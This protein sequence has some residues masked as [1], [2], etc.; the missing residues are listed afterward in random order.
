MKNKKIYLIFVF[1]FAVLAVNLLL[2]LQVWNPSWNPFRPS[3]TIALAKMAFRMKRVDAFHALGEVELEMENIIVSSEF[4][5]DLE[6]VNDNESKIKGS[7]KI[8][9]FSER[10]EFLTMNDVFYLNPGP[11]T[12]NIEEMTKNRFVFGDYKWIKIDQESLDSL[13][14]SEI[15]KTHPIL[16]MSGEEWEK[17]TEEIMK[18]FTERKY[19][20]I[21]AELEDEEIDGEMYYHYLISLNEEEIQRMADRLDFVSD[22]FADYQ[23]NTLEDE[24]KIGDLKD[25]DFEVWIDQDDYYLYQIKYEEND[26]SRSLVT[27]INFSD[28]NQEQNINP[29]EE[30]VEIG[31]ILEKIEE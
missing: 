15:S 4:D 23:N 2:Y 24:I 28:F 8:P 9:M 26:G 10:V 12:V 29:P 21:E 30:F 11:Y 16:S 14:D 20:E 18:L 7:F 31:E 3:P 5:L 13:S 17:L 6:K 1:I 25:L 19:Y 22:Y 27:K